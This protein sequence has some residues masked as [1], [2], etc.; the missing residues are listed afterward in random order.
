MIKL[1]LGSHNKKIEGYT[2]VD[3]LKLENV[4]IV[5]NLIDFPYPFENES[6]DEILMVEVLEHISWRKTEAVLKEC[7]RILKTG[8]KLHIQVPDI[9][10][11]MFCYWNEQICPCVPHKPKDKADSITKLDCPNCKG[12]GRVNPMRWKMA[13][14]GAQKH[15]YD[16]HLN[17]FTPEIL[18]ENLENAGFNKIDIGQDEYGWKIKCNCIK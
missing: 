7:H 12:Y 4:D 5:H 10:D 14:L 17:I 15:E 6:V 13:F 2:N 18:E 8:G 11:M 9:R 1:N 3:A 16:T